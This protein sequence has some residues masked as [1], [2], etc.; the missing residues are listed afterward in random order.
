MKYLAKYW[1]F[2]GI[3]V[4][5]SLAFAIPDPLSKLFQYPVLKTGI[6]L[7]FLITGLKL[8]TKMIV[9]EIRSFKALF[10]SLLSCFVL[11][12][13]IAVPL[14][15]LVCRLFSVTDHT[16]LIVG[17]RLNSTNGIYTGM[18]RVLSGKDGTVLHSFYGDV[19]YAGLGTSV[20]GAGDLNGDGF[21][22]VMAGAPSSDVAG[23][24]AGSA[25][26]F[27]GSDG[28]TLHTFHGEFEYDGIG[29]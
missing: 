16:D 20:S 12:P 17:S 7:A 6:F 25:Y 29:G 21:A 11:W 8:E 27:S 10:C 14:A 19:L 3:A 1:F 24:N 5:I 9:Q 15:Y 26:V 2:I 18:A 28:S 22:D 23:R 4:V 13:I